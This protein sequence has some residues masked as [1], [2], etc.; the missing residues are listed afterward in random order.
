MKKKIIRT[1]FAP[2]P[3]GYLHIGGLRTALYSY[4]LAK[5]SGGKFYLRIDDTDKKREVAGAR[6]KI[7]EILKLFRISWDEKPVVQ[8][9]RVKTGVYERAAMSLIRSGHAF[10]CNCPPR[11]VKESGVPKVLRDPC[12]NKN[13][14][15]GAIKLMVPEGKEI[16]FYDFVMDRKVSWNSSEVADTILLKSDGFPT[17]HLAVVVDDH[18]MGITHVIRGVEWLSSTPIHL[19]VYDYL[20]IEAPLIGHISSILDPSGGKLSKRKGNVAV[21]Q[22]LEEGYLPEAIINFVILLGWSP[23][24]NRELFTLEEFVEAFDIKGLQKSN[25]IFNKDKL[26]WFNG[27]YIRKKSDGEL[28]HLLK[29]FVTN[30][31]DESLM[32]RIIPL[33]KERLTKL[34]DFENLAGF[35]FAFRKPAP[36]LFGKNY[37]LHL[38]EALKVISQLEDFNLDSLNEGLMRAVKMNNFKTGD[39]FMDLR[40]AIAGSKITPPIN[41]SMV[42]L[43]KEETVKRL[44]YALY[45][46]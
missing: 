5:H 34:S 29:P 35:F 10:Y 41:E 18:E 23:K 13:L 46:I 27:Y 12:R 7:F 39:F 14:S 43:G 22:F 17:Y 20:G 2:S 11:N 21:E 19:L 33:V 24:D 9:E 26:D 45:E 3:T 38:Q 16:E 4:A 15:S 28:L 42:I 1:R 37:K 36:N 32:S 30:V 31:F 8:S 25:P 6:E 40:V 44:K